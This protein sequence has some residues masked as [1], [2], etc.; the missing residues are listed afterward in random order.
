MVYPKY[1]LTQSI[2]QNLARIEL[3]KQSFEKT[4]ISPVLLASLRDTAKTSSIHYS[5]QIEG[6]RLTKEEVANV[7]KGKSL[8]AKQRDEKEVKAYYDALV[9][10]ESALAKNAS[11][12]E[13]LISKIHN[14]VEGKKRSIPYRDGQNAIYDSATRAK[15][16]LPPEAKDVPS[17]MKKLVEWTNEN[18]KL[19]VPLLAGIVHYQFV[20]IHPYYDGNGRTARLLTTFIMRKFGCDLKGI[21]SLEEYYAKNLMA[22][23]EAL[24]THPHHNYYYGRNK[25]DI[26]NWLEYFIAGVKD[27]F[28]NVLKHAEEIPH[29]TQDKTTLMRELNIKQRRVLE[30]FINFKE[31]TS[32]QVA[33]TLSISVGAA[34][35]LMR[36]FMENDFLVPANESKKA[37]TYRLAEKYQEL[38]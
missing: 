14:L 30:L 8:S 29:M 9:Y 27:A 2:V 32:T 34:R 33:E 28:E 21:Y 11:F 38:V 5:T 13:E 15:I 22:Y 36:E 26:T 6:N 23:Y 25:A 37:R 17:L 12:S 7:L 20:T 18:Q 4:P 10:V 16:Y 19:T 1:T 24:Q 3:V 31:I 35:A